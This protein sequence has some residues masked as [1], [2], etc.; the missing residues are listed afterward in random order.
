MGWA[1][2]CPTGSGLNPRVPRPSRRESPDLR[3]LPGG[4]HPTIV[5][6]TREHEVN[7]QA[8]LAL[9]TNG[10]VFQQARHLVRVSDRGAGEPTIEPISP[11]TLREELARSAHWRREKGD[12]RTPA[13]PP[14]WSIRAILDRGTYGP[15][16]WLRL[17]TV[18]PVLAPDGTVLQD[19]GYHAESGVLYRPNASYP[20][21]ADAPSPEDV[22]RATRA[23]LNVV[24]DFPFL[25]DAHRAAW[26][27][28]L[29]TPFARLAADGPAPL[30]MIDASL[31]GTGKTLLGDIIGLIV[32]GQ[33]LP[34][35]PPCRNEEEERKRI[36]SLVLSGARIAFLDNVS[37]LLGSATFDAALTA[38]RWKDRHLGRNVMAEGPLQVTW[39]ATGNNVA[40]RGDT[41]RR[42]LLIRLE[43]AIECPERRT[44][45]QHPNLRQA[46][47]Q[48]RAE[49]VS[50]CLVL[51]RH[52][53]TAPS[54]A[55]LPEWG[56]FERWSRVVRG[57][58]VAAGLP[59]PIQGQSAML[60][61]GDDRADAAWILL[62]A[63]EELGVAESGLK[64]RELLEASRENA[65][66]REA[67]RELTGKD[68]NNPPTSTELAAKLRVLKGTVVDGRIFKHGERTNTGVSWYF[69]RIGQ[70]PNIRTSDDGDHAAPLDEETEVRL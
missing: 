11:A 12:K 55:A 28:A 26:L 4:D 17:I 9:A 31:P 50:H 3:P 69:G 60:R 14:E 56:S 34:R 61:A 2:T 39:I 68:R 62:E 41:A 18:T 22:S 66:M 57:A 20:R 30:M 35:L 52:G 37:G 64:A 65:G 53:V 10:A 21:V 46:V 51:L 29:L 67:V 36:T 32:T 43:S 5:I 27:A 24:V 58:V 70:P 38:D 40:L 49:L 45:F 54:V 13:H 33:N 42:T 63:M 19:A 59:D 8:V 1:E 48:Y 44:G 15:V 47:L 25:N 16:R 6:T 23:L 7:D